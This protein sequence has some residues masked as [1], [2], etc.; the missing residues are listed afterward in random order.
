M[1]KA[2]S[3]L[4]TQFAQWD[5]RVRDNM[6]T[7]SLPDSEKST[8]RNLTLSQNIQILRSRIGE[9]GITEPSYNVR[10][11]IV[12][13]LSYQVFKTLPQRKM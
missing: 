12:S 3:L 6:I 1:L 2:R 8:L 4:R 5:S 11:K 10:A 9:L 7:L 13:V